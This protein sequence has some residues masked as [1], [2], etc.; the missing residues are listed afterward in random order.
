MAFPHDEVYLFGPFDREPQLRPSRAMCDRVQPFNWGAAPSPQMYVI[1]PGACL[2]AN[3]AYGLGGPN[4]LRR[5]ALGPCLQSRTLD[6]EAEVH[7]GSC[8]IVDA[9]NGKGSDGVRKE[10]D[11]ATTRIWLKSRAPPP[12]VAAN[13]NS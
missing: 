5:H 8:T 7:I 2:S 11:W 10:A 13:S 1:V 4:G 6:R 9:T 12:G 3:G